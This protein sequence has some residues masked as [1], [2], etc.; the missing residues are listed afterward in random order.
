MAACK[1]RGGQAAVEFVLMYAAV[2][3]PLTFGIVYVSEMYWVWHSMAEFT[4]K[5][6]LYAVTHCWQQGGGNVIAYMQ[7]AVP[8]NIDTI[9][10]QNG[11]TAQITVEYSAFSADSGAPALGAPT[12]DPTNSICV[13]DTVTVSVTNYEFRRFVTFLN[14]PPVQMP[15]F[16]TSLAIQ[17]G[18]A[19]PDNPGNCVEQ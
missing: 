19:D 7:Q 15:D 18:G 13:P 17:S 5:G 1:R 3:L 8:V 9:Q 10:F 11:G 6:A 12:C 2:I 14:L 4:R 16:R